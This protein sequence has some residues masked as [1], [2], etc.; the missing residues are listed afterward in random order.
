[1]NIPTIHPPGL[2]KGDT[3]AVIAPAGPV[4]G[5]EGLQKGIAVLEKMGFMV[6]YSDRIFQSTRYLAGDDAARA[7]ELVHALEDNSVQAIIGLRGGYGCSRLVPKLM[8]AKSLQQPKVFMGF[9]D[10]TTLHLF[11]NRRL[12]WVTLHGPMVMTMDW[13]K[14]LIELESHLFSLL[15]D[16]EYRPVLSFPQLETWEPGKAE[17]VLAGGCLSMIT[18][19]IGTP[20]EIETEGKILF[21]EDLGE[22]P[23]RLDRMITQLQLSGKLQ[24]IKG[25][26]LGTFN[27]CDP[28]EGDYSARD[29]LKEMLRV[30]HI[31]ILAN[32]PAGHGS[33]NWPFPL[34][35]KVRIDADTRSVEFLEPAVS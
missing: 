20:Y 34:G 29:V 16:P 17:G 3:V 30:L 31:P 1:M 15:T 25:I 10:L 32:F 21:L 13:D 27:E 33:E 22:Q 11:L 19:S 12:G 18:A 26:I 7:E 24:S 28:T 23:Y 2:K 35:V 14:P 6:R 9:S 8:T 4:Q 5:S